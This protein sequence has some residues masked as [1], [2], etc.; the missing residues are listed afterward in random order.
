M[1][2]LL[3]VLAL[4]V[5]HGAAGTTAALRERWQP[6]ALSA[7]AGISI[8]Y[9]FLDLIPTLADG[10]EVIDASGI[11]PGLESHVFVLTLVGL[12]VAFWVETV[13]RRS[14]RRRREA[15][16]A[17][18]TGDGP[19]WLGIVSFVILNAAIGYIVAAPG[20][21]AVEPLWLF[22]IAM[23][24]HFIVNDHAMAEHHGERYRR[25]GRWLLVAGLLAGWVVGMVPALE[26]PPPALALV[27][28]YLAGGVIFNIL[29]HELPDTD[30]SASVLAFG[31]GAAVYG[32]LVLTLTPTG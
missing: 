8:A 4:A 28:G 30:R 6:R 16:A 18:E 5:V 20:D 7:A 2:S 3:T 26:I 12:T 11:L 24:L 31:V 29:R 23:G 1:T 9:V 27:V 21:E 22:A 32:A 10:Q 14:H 15:G 25:W 13:A 17:A 19:F